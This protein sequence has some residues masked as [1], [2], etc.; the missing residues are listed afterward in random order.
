[1][2]FCGTALKRDG[3]TRVNHQQSLQ[4]TGGH[5]ALNGERREVNDLRSPIPDNDTSLDLLR[6]GFYDQ[7]NLRAGRLC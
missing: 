3:D 7:L 5:S 2:K 6:A 1:M 4:I